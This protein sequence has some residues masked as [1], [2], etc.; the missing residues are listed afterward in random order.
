MMVA[1]TGKLVMKDLKDDWL[2][3]VSVVK[4]ESIGYA[5]HLNVEHTKERSGLTP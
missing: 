3:S 5:D 1:W 4:M 2:E